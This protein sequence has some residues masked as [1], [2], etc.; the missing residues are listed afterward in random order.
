MLQYFKVLVDCCA[1]HLESNYV[2]D[3]SVKGPLY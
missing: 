3:S 1:A 2:K